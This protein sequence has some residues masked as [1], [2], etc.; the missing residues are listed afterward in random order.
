VTTSDDELQSSSAPEAALALRNASM[1]FAGVRVLDNV[2]LTLA[3]GEIRALVGKNGSGK[4]TLIKILSG[5]HRPL[6][7]AA[8][9]VGG[10]VHRF[11]VTPERLRALGL[12]FVHQD[13]GLIPDATVLDNVL[14]GRFSGGKL[15][16]V[17]WRREKERVLSILA[18]FE[19]D[20]P[21]DR[22][23][24]LLSPVERAFVAIAR[25]F[26]DAES[27]SGVLVLD[28]PTA[29]LPQ[30]EVARLFG[31]IR[32]I[33][34]AGQAIL[35]VSHRL[36]EVLG[37]AES[38]TVLRDGRT[39]HEG[40]TAGLIEDDLVRAILGEDAKTFYPSLAPAAVD[41]VFEVEGLTGQGLRDVS[42]S[43]HRGEI[44]GVTGLAGAGWEELPYLIAGAAAAAGGRLRVAGQDLAATSL[45]PD[46][47]RR[48]GIALLPADR[49]RASGAQ[50]LTLRENVS[51]P[52]LSRYFRFGLMDGSG[53]RDAV[54]KLLRAFGVRPP[55]PDAPL[56]TL[57]G[58]NQQKALLG[59][60]I[61]T[62]P[63]I[64]VLHEPTQGVDVGSK[65][66]IFRKIDDIAA[67]G[68]G[69]VMASAES[70]DLARLCH[71]VVVL[72][73]GQIG[74]VLE[75]NELSE[76]AINNLSFSRPS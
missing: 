24:R 6:P 5:Y 26:V 46:K 37:L 48:F 50:E 14:V 57:S 47:T 28:E 65:Q 59:K 74:G 54:T 67:T 44:L 66:D 55:K 53:E 10:H 33:A 4:S 31:A 72:H 61:Q 73:R 19:L 29:F 7:G 35:Y 12:S 45:S 40:P 51:L 38:V 3:P 30:D 16:P 21:L 60:W 2:S 49:Q 42:L 52:V 39:V 71:R 8:L 64:L 34:S 43:L 27:H 41:I 70:E 63:K 9:S 17:R 62:A 18:R 20:L 25:S 15:A 76:D 58:G 68:V 56:R 36:D 11:P 75:A 23:V 13:L 1:A 22:P 32:A 69:I